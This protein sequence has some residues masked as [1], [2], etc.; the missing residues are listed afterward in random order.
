MLNVHQRQPHIGH[1][2]NT[3]SGPTLWAFI[4]CWWVDTAMVGLLVRSYMAAVSGR[5]HRLLCVTVLDARD[6]S[7]L[8]WFLKCLQL[9]YRVHL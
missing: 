9:T 3:Q 4:V 8:L 7:G 1:F 2:L 6:L 5:T